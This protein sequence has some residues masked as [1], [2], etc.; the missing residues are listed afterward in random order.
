[1]IKKK[2]REE[3]IMKTLETKNAPAAICHVSK[4]ACCLYN[5]VKCETSFFEDCSNVLAGLLCLSL[6]LV[7]CNFACSRV[8]RD[9]T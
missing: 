1:M 8:Y 6:D 3:F 9:L 2:V 5:V 4:E 7:A